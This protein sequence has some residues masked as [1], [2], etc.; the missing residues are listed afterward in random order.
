MSQTS[1]PWS[2]VRA[3]KAPPIKRRVWIFGP[4]PARIQALVDAL[5]KAGHE[6]KPGESGGELAPALRDYRPDLIVIDMQ[7]AAD[8]G[9]HLATQLR[10][11]RA[12]RQLPIVLVGIKGEEGNKAERA[13]Q[14][15]TRR[16]ALSLDTPSVLGALVCEL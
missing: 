16:Y 2:S 1:S 10:A 11:D 12:T 8:R 5:E 7:D 15:P 13:C 4:N 14:G 3:A 9:R 6:G